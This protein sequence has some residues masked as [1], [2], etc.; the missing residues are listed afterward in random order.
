MGCVHRKARLIKATG[1]CCLN[2][3]MCVSQRRSLLVREVTE[4]EDGLMVE[5]W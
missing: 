2:V 1:D 5:G 3:Y 4:K